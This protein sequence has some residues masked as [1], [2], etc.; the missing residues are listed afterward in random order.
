MGAAYDKA[1]AGLHD[2]GQPHLAQEIIA[3]R[4]IGIA[5]TVERDPDELARRA[6]RRWGWELSSR[7]PGDALAVAR[8]NHEAV[9]ERTRR[10]GISLWA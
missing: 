8:R 4:I 10:H 1:R 7:C 2:K 3:K 6:C 9:R 5:A